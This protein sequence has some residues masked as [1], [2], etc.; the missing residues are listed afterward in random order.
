MPQLIRPN[1]VRVVTEGGECT[2]HIVLELN[3]NVRSDGAVGVSV[4]GGEQSKPAEEGGWEIPNFS[5]GNKVKFGQK[6]E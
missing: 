6:G 3:I 1:E 4:K 2:V 5:S